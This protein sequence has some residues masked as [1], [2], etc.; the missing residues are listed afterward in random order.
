MQQFKIYTV[1]FIRQHMFDTFFSGKE[2]L[3]EV[4]VSHALKTTYGELFITLIG[5]KAASEQLKF[6]K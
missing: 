3:V 1:S 2:Y 6:T 5:T 4:D